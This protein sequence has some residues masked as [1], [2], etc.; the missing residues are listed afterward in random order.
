MTGCRTTLRDTQLVFDVYRSNV[1]GKV[2]FQMSCEVAGVVIF[3]NRYTVSPSTVHRI[4]EFGKDTTRD[5][6]I[7]EED[8]IVKSDRG[9]L[10]F[11]GRGR[12]IIVVNQHLETLLN[13][14]RDSEIG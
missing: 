3:V 10:R 12:S 8:C 6:N 9:S 13:C 11:S 7:K 5:F 4:V 2:V 1:V 14:L